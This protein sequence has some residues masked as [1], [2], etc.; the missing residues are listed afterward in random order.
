[1]KKRRFTVWQCGN[2]IWTGKQ[3]CVCVCV[4]VCVCGE[5]LWNECVSKGRH[6]L[7]QIQSLYI[8][9]LNLQCPRLQIHSNRS[10]V[11]RTKVT[12]LSVHKKKLSPHV[13]S[14][15]LDMTLFKWLTHTHTHTD[16]EWISPEITLTQFYS[17]EEIHRFPD[18]LLKRTKGRLHMVLN[19]KLFWK[20]FKSTWHKKK[21][22]SASV[23]LGPDNRMMYS[24]HQRALGWDNI[25]MEVNVFLFWLI[26]Q[27]AASFGDRYPKILEGNGRKRHAEA[28][29]FTRAHTRWTH[30]SL[31][32]EW[33]FL[34]CFVFYLRRTVP[35]WGRWAGLT[36]SSWARRLVSERR[37][38]TMIRHEKL[39]CHLKQ[40]HTE[41]QLP[42]D[43]SAS[44][45]LAHWDGPGPPGDA[46]VHM[47]SDPLAYTHTWHALQHAKISLITYALSQRDINHRQARRE[48]GIT[49][50]KGCRSLLAAWTDRYKKELKEQKQD[51]KT[52][53]QV[54][55]FSDLVYT[56]TGLPCAH[57]MQPYLTPAAGSTHGGLST[58]CTGRLHH[59]GRCRM[60]CSTAQ[61]C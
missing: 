54:F 27:W 36:V 29:K 20:P 50:I 32:C 48:G 26:P 51:K 10:L 1:M 45:P 15:C 38:R 49:N 35:L 33:A 47:I 9:I 58:W 55:F 31:V 12:T 42:P 39:F 5:G 18:K 28:C 30:L 37:G 19:V 22:E 14:V 46:H 21:K 59:W 3:E 41:R 61:W 8:F 60:H 6:L 57:F 34:S 7:M 13:L 52:E 11:V 25:D 23:L 17:S 44:V 2:W 40:G 43:T 24:L 4:C 53:K 16:C 56:E